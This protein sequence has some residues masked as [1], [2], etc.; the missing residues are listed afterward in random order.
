MVMNAGESTS[1]S[2]PLQGA[3]AI[4]C[5]KCGGSV[6]PVPGQQ[7]LSCGY[8][9][10]IV[11]NNSA[12]VSLDRITPVDAATDLCCPTCR[13]G[14][15]CGELDGRKALYC[16]ECFGVL[17]RHEDF[18]T[19]VRERAER[20]IGG[21]PAEPRPIDPAAYER[22][23]TCPSCDGRMEVHPYYGPGNVVI[24]SCA[25]CGFVWLDQGEI[26]RIERAAGGFEKQR[27]QEPMPAV[28][29][30]QSSSFGVE[31]DTA[32]TALTSLAD[33]LFL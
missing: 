4:S 26:T 13:G 6:D 23:L 24:D 20:R 9:Q 21:E 18:S 16:S 8:C 25:E 31:R 15:K 2:R 30:D 17:L 10:S 14:M 29:G 28:T 1:A 19:V 3:R 5:P 33:L 27:T 32:T 22:H 7:Y 11:L 12:T